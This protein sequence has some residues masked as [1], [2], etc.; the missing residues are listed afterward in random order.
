[1]NTIETLER[2]LQITRDKI[3]AHSRYGSPL[4]LTTFIDQEKALTKEIDSLK[5]DKVARI[6][7]RVV[8][9]QSSYEPSEVNYQLLD[10][11]LFNIIDQLQREQS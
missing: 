10:Y 7:E 6:R 8:N 4:V 11:V 3:D 9:F 1:M 5:C 2:S